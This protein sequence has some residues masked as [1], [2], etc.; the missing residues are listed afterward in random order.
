MKD[1]VIV[2]T[3]ASR[4][5]G[6]ALAKHYAEVGNTVVGLSRSC[7]GAAPGVDMFRCDLGSP[8][9]IARAMDEVFKKHKRID[10][11]V[12]NAAVLKSTPVLFLTND[13][14]AGM[15]NVNF[16]GAAI[17]SREAAKQM[18]R[19]KGGRIV[20]ILSMAQKLALPGDAVYAATKAAL[21]TF[22]QVLNRELHSSNITVN[23]LAV[24]AFPSQM[25]DQVTKGAPEKIKQHIPH[26]ALA[27]VADIT[28]AIDFFCSATSSDVGGQTIYLGGV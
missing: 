18:L 15:V 4:G 26:G 24:S 28:G 7:E 8:A 22:G 17:A 10:V 27:G 1:K 19:K 14:I 23:S 16:V 13:D 3:G 20:N 12:N 2:I 9:D 21:E 5:L 6:G 11:L 25:L